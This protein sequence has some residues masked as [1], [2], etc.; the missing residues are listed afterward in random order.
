MDCWWC[1]IGMS[2]DS[3][4]SAFA[5][6]LNHLMMYIKCCMDGVWKQ[7]N[8]RLCISQEFS[9]LLEPMSL[10]PGSYQI[11]CCRCN[12]PLGVHNTS[13]DHILFHVR[14]TI[15]V[16]SYRSTYRFPQIRISIILSRLIAGTV[17]QSTSLSRVT[18]KWYK[19]KMARLFDLQCLQAQWYQGWNLR[20][21]LHQQNPVLLHI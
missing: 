12:K 6:T 15:Y 18:M 10:L 1:H 20:W 3:C 9:W 21:V 14:G 7:I 4:H 17:Q 16:F 19:P 11:W 5:E 2:I 8:C 13:P